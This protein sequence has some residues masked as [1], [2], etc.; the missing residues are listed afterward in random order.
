MRGWSRT[1]AVCEQPLTVKHSVHRRFQRDVDALICQRRHDLARRIVTKALARE[2]IQHPLALPRRQGIPRRRLWAT[3]AVFGLSA[4]ALKRALVDAQLP[5]ASI[6]SRTR[7]R[8]ST[9][10]R[11]PRPPVQQPLPIAA[12]GR[13]CSSC[14]PSRR[15]SSPSSASESPARSRPR[16]A[17]PRHSN[18]PDAVRR[19]FEAPA[20]FC[21]LSRPAMYAR[22][23][24]I[25][26]ASAD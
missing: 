20:R 24:A 6:S 12:T 26:R 16:P 25:S 18:P 10:W 17:S 23:A 11:H 1:T 3:A 2:Y 4:P 13:S 7:R 22:H 14:N 15:K 19:S 5:A 8:S 9:L 21:V